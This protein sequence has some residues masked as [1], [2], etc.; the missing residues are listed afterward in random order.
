MHSPKELTPMAPV[1]TPAIAPRLL[2][3]EQGDAAPISNG[4]PKV[5]KLPVPQPLAFDFYWNRFL[6]LATSPRK[7]L[8]YIKFRNRTRTPIVDYLP[9]IFDVEPISRCNFHCTMCQ[10]SDWPKY[11]RA[12]DL[13]IE[14]FKKII[15]SQ[16]GLLEVKLQGYGEP[17]LARDAFF[18]MVKYAR[19]HHLWVRT[20]TNASLLHLNGNYKKMIDSGI[21]EVQISID[22]ATKE[23]FEKIR[24][25]SKFEQVIENCKLINEYSNKKRVVRT[26]M[27]STIQRENVHEFFDLLQLA[28]DAGFK[29]LTYSLNLHGMGQEKWVNQNHTI[30]AL[31]CVT[32]DMCH[33]AI[34][35]GKTLGIDVTF[36]KATEKYSTSS[37]KTVCAWPFERIFVSSDLRI[38]PCCLISN[39]QTADLGDAR[40]F[41]AEWNGP[42]FQEFRKAHLEGR[43]PYYCQ[44][45]YDKNDQPSSLK[46]VQQ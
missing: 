41:T 9:I 33:E 15:D 8:N 23:I 3:S 27:W 5:A 16:Y 29:R 10:V 14:E 6:A 25:G 42:V 38:V 17:T 40:N 20:T 30:S 7:L 12:A 34:K 11:Q 13:P 4:G 31:E 22:G 37:A 28:K 46:I 36:W 43:I 21:N 45:C 26:R 18:E 2:Q 24:R 19:K 44:E 1:E 35:R 32:D 39:P